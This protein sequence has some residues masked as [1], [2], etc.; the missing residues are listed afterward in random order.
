MANVGVK[1]IDVRQTGTALVF[2]ASLKDANGAKVTAGTTTVYL[3]ELQSDGTLKSYDFASNTFK[4]TALTT[5]TAAASHQTGNNGTT[6]TGVWTYALSTLTGFTVGA[7]YLATFSNSS[8]SPPQQEREFQFGS[9][10]GDLVTTS[11]GTGAAT[12]QADARQLLGTA[13]VAPAVAGTPDV[14]S[15]Q[16]GGQAVALDAN[17]FPKVALWSILGSLL[18]ETTAGWL[19][20]GVKKFFNVAAATSTMNQLT[21]VDTSTTVTGGATS[22][23]QTTLLTAVNA[24]TTNTARSSPR[25]PVF[26]PRPVSGSSVYLADLFLYNLQGVLEDADSNTITVHAR[27]SVG[28]S[29]DSG[30]TSTTMTRVAAGQYRFTY[31]VASADLTEAVYFDFSW[32]IGGTSNKDGAATEVQDAENYATLA[33]IRAKTDNLPA[34]PAAVGSQMAL[35]VAYDA[36]KTAATQTSVTAL[37]SPQQAGPVTLAASQPNYAPARSTDPMTLTSAY[38]PAK[39]ASQASTALSNAVWTNTKA[40]YLDSPISGAG[41]GSGG[42]SAEEIDELLAANHGVGAWGGSIFVTPFAAT[43]SSGEV[44]DSGLIVAYQFAHFGSYLVAVTDQLG[45]PINLEGADLRFVAYR[46]RNRIADSKYFELTTEANQLVVSG[47]GHNQ[48]TID[49]TDDV[50]QDAIEGYWAIRNQT[51]DRVIARGSLRIDSI[52]DAEAT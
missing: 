9:H 18:S 30:L 31:T 7:M 14:N 11:N 42:A 23:S 37:G 45:L 13:W 6:N 15:K 49:A 22:A 35:T 47:D 34:A 48:V 12:I 10:Q 3:Y 5:E 32:T 52:P 39:T 27:N 41:G 20:A 16:L 24:I 19:S 43:V 4:T 44:A 40:S 17:N 21:L 46:L 29:R 8:A 28:T 36:A 26:M 33:A 2:R 38:D 51:T 1:G 50:T 25:V